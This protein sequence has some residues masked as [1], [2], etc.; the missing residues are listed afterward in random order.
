MSEKIIKLRKPLN[1]NKIRELTM[2]EPTMKQLRKYG[3]PVDGKSQSIDFEKAAPMIAE[4]TGVQSVFI[5]EMGARDAL[6]AVTALVQLA[7]GFRVML[8]RYFGLPDLLAFWP[9]TA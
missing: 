5:E 8:P 7:G 9:T 1:E 4:L 3:I 6:D 2:R